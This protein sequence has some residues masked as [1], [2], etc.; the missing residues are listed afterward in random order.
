MKL[1]RAL[2]EVLLQRFCEDLEATATATVTGRLANLLTEAQDLIFKPFDIKPTDQKYFIAGSARL[3]LY[4]ELQEL[5]KLKPL[6]DLDFVVPGKEEWTKLS[7]FL[8]KNPNPKIKP[9][10]VQA[11]RY[12]PH[13]F[14]EAFDEWLPK[15]DEEAVKDFSVRTTTD[16]LRNAKQVGGYY[17]M[18]LYDIMDYKL[19]LN[20][21]K[22]KQMTDL[23]IRYQ[24]ANSATEKQEIK[25]F[26]L[27]LFAGNEEDA[28]DFLAP[29]LTRLSKLN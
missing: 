26:V 2:N 17:F 19:N 21:D 20:R 5:L 8:A 29:A 13:E 7:A 24:K 28:N 18:S 9:S 25:K 14:I 23:L 10:D 22:E 15:F 3:Y 11:G 4:P 16:I 1:K 6:G 12:I 27:G